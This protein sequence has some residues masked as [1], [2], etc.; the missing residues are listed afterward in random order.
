VTYAWIHKDKMEL[1]TWNY[2]GRVVK[3]GYLTLNQELKNVANTRQD[4]GCKQACGN[5]KTDFPT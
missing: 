4:A 2:V 3:F 5:S 1:S